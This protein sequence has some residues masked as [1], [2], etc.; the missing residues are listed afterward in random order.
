MEANADPN[1]NKCEMQIF[2]RKIA[3]SC[4]CNFQ[5]QSSNPLI[6]RE[7]DLVYQKILEQ[8]SPNYCQS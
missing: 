3:C 7:G 8:M 5:S 1:E 4:M 2:Q 6:L